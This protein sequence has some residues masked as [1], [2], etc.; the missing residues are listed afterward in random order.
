MRTHEAEK[1]RIQRAKWMGA[2]AAALICLAFSYDASAVG[3]RDFSADDGSMLIQVDDSQGAGDGKS[4]DGKT[5]ETDKSTA[6]TEGDADP[7][8]PGTDTSAP[9]VDV[10]APDV[11]VSAP[12]TDASAPDADVSAPD[13]DAGTPD[14]DAGTPDVDANAPDVD[15]DA[16]DVDANAP[17]VDV[18]AP[19]VEVDAPDVDVGAPSV[20]ASAPA[21]GN[22]QPLEAA[23]QGQASATPTS[24]VA[25][26][27]VREAPTGT[28]LVPSGRSADAVDAKLTSVCRAGDPK[29]AAREPSPAPATPTATGALPPANPAPARPVAAAHGSPLAISLVSPIKARD[30]LVVQGIVF[31][32]SQEPQAVPPIQVT[33]VNKAGQA[34]QQWTIKPPVG[35]LP[36]GQ[37]K[38]FKA[39]LQPVPPNVSRADAAFLATR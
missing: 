4:S 8:A 10:S 36:P 14:V 16:P 5:S 30:G 31:N 21:P 29:C 24:T 35:Q 19:G 11:D 28:I 15:V 32:S 37:N 1:R 23:P 26:A 34:L 33:L 20:D 13:A 7:S 3:F 9:D 12:D 39:V 27:V 2:S 6:G 25:S 17:D 22:G 18:D 38:A